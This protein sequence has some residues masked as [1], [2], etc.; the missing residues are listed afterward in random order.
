MGGSGSGNR[1]RIGAKSTTA[2]YRTLDVRRWAREGMLTP[3]V[4]GGGKW[5]CGGETVASMQTHVE[6]DRVILFYRH[7]SGGEEW[8]DEWQP[9]RILCTPCNFGGSRPWFICPEPGCGRRVAILYGGGIFA[10]RHCHQLAYSSAR[11][12]PGDRA[13]KRADRLRARL[14]W[15]PGILNGGGGKPKWMRWRTFERLTEEH[16]RLVQRAL[17]EW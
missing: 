16:D 17:R 15:E 3:G 10:C 11:K 9:V 8:S 13:A 5:T 7:R 2:D 1:W 14:G 12:S 4:L 6:H